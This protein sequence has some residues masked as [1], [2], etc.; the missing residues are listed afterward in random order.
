MEASRNARYGHHRSAVPVA[1]AV[2]VTILFA[3]FPA[4]AARKTSI[5]GTVADDAGLGL[6]GVTVQCRPRGGG[7]PRV[8]VTGGD[9]SFAIEGLAP[10]S[11]TVEAQMPGFEPGRAEVSLGRDEVVSLRFTLAPLTFSDTVEV[12]AEEGGHGTAELLA[13]RREAAMVTDAI[14]SEDI[15]TSADSDAGEVVQRLTGVSIVNGKY[16]FV[17]GLGERYSHVTL[18]GA[19]ISTTEPEKRVVPLDLFPSG[20]LE[21]VEVSKTYTPDREGEFGGGSL[22]LTSVDFPRQFEAGATLGVGFNDATTGNPFGRYGGGLSWR[23][24]GGQPIPGDVPPE[25]L[26]RRSFVNPEGLSPEELQVIGRSFGPTWE[27]TVESSAPMDG[28]AGFSLG[29]PA[30]KRIGWLLHGIS[31]HDFRTVA[32]EIQNYYGLDEGSLVPRNDYRLTTDTESVRNGLLGGLGYRFSDNHRVNLSTLFIRNAETVSRFQEGYNSNDGNNIRDLRLHFKKEDI[33][34]NRVAGV[35]N[36]PGI[37]AGSELTWDVSYAQSSRDFDL[38]EN[39]YHEI[40]PGVYWLNVGAPES[41]KIEYHS[42]DEDLADLRVSWSTFFARDERSYGSLKGGLAYSDRSRGFLARRFRFVTRDPAQFDLSLPPEQLFV[43]GNI[44]PDGWEIR[45]QTGF[46]DTYEGTHTIAGAFLM[47]DWTTGRWRVIG[48]LRAERSEQSVV[49]TNPF[50]TSRPVTSTLEGTDWLPGINVVYAV[51]ENTNLRLALSRTVN[52]PDFRELSPFYFQEV[53]GGWGTAGNPDLTG[54]RIHGADIRLETFPEPGE[55]MAVSAFYKRI[56]DPIE[57]IIIPTTEYLVSYVNADEA[58]LYGA[59]IE[60]R[61]GLGILW[62]A[63]ADCTLNLNYTYT[64]SEVTIPRDGLSAI[65][66]TSRPLEG[67]ATH[68]G[69]L[70]LAYER[71]EWGTSLKLLFNYTGRRIGNVGA[72]GLPDI[73]QSARRGLDFVYSQQLS[74]LAPGLSF[75]LTGSN[76]LDTKYEWLQGGSIQQQYT[77]GRT[78]GLSVAYSWGA[79]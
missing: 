57:R 6:P 30:G 77:V 22:D 14:S 4:G 25:R 5:A 58:V 44:R 69:N 54:A 41:G 64:H 45:E 56:D 79:P 20:M 61:R 13:R 8:A 48:G 59:E 23:G 12:R 37:G 74:F 51:H 72:F 24:T 49:T 17:R 26:V 71:T 75:K 55:V 1:L 38:R 29:G 40:D 50:D 53:T 2:F 78:W 76:L 52:R 60:F 43:P 11:Y 39:L 7:E 62:H 47:G 67:Q 21:T 9:G 3:A 27:P 18:N 19:K 31:S 70:S 42:L 66:S 34:I 33:F 16:V 10:G 32:D 68:V 36:F 65:T 28:K 35:H 63:L 73:Y 46:N 15:A